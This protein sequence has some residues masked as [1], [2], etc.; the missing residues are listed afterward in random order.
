M[1]SYKQQKGVGEL[2][3][4]VLSEIRKWTEKPAGPCGES[5]QPGIWE[6]EPDAH[7]APWPASPP[8]QGWTEELCVR[9][10]DQ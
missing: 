2:N 10:P 8:H 4:R 6:G 1:P 7:A 3:S 9:A 5:G